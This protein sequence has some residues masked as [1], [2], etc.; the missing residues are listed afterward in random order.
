MLLAALLLSFYFP[1]IK[2]T[3]SP[4][5]VLTYETDLTANHCINMFNAPRIPSKKTTCLALLN[6]RLCRGGLFLLG[7]A[8]ILPEN[9]TCNPIWK[10]VKR[11]LVAGF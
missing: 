9:F 10:E 11:V 2:P 3:R 5:L 8:I 1:S 4:T 6:I 7:I